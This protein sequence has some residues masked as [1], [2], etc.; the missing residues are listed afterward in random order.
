MTQITVE[1][2]TCARIPTEAGE[3]QLCYF[4]NNQDSKEHL[5]LIFGDITQTSPIL[6]RIHSECFT[7]DV[8]GSRR[9]DCGPQLQSAMEMIAAEG[10]GVIVYLRQEGRGIGLLDKLRAYN[11]QDLGYDTIDANL[12][13]GH[14][15]DARDYTIAALI[16][17]ELRIES[18]R[19]ITNNPVKIES[20]EQLGV[21]VAERVSIQTAVHADNKVYLSTKVSRMRHL[22]H[23]N[24]G[25]NGTMNGR[26]DDHSAGGNGRLQPT[27]LPTPHLTPHPTR[28]AVT[29]SYAQ[30]L[31]GSITAKRGQ[32]TAISGDASM[33]LT[34]QLRASHDAILVGIG[35]VLA[36]NP[37]LNVRLAEGSDPQPIIL[38]TE[39][40][41]PLDARL[42][43]N[44]R[45]PWIA[46]SAHA[47]QAKQSALEATGAKVLRFPVNEQ[48]HVDLTTVLAKLADAHIHSVMVEGGAQI[49][50]AFLN[51]QL[52]DRVVLTIA[53]KF[54]GGY[55][56]V[57][58]M[59]GNGRLHPHLINTH[60]TQMGDDLIVFGDAVWPEAANGQGDDAA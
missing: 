1:K 51:S 28:P 14:Q 21:A 37:R 36:D 53:P 60:T 9:C 43:Q 59:S 44:K 57:G 16:L 33:K 4:K 56:A 7:G 26:S 19:L 39:L 40:R 47:S 10:R 30:S 8:L 18:L 42:L 5:A 32:P 23:I 27:L 17:Q 31:D 2:K 20:L 48:G 25:E 34:H 54:I 15:A 46:T 35:T 24:E 29:L 45:C 6:T 13:L 55:H 11:L 41:F 38:D 50:T 52:V 12:L 3:F 58:A 22:L 49:I